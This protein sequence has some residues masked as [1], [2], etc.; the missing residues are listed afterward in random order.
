MQLIR[1]VRFEEKPGAFADRDDIEYILLEFKNLDFIYW[2]SHR[3]ES[4]FQIPKGYINLG[5][6]FRRYLFDIMNFKDDPPITVMVDKKWKETW[7]LEG[8]DEYDKDKGMMIWV[9]WKSKEED[10]EIGE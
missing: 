9:S 4:K 1:A 10:K 2:G 7:D 3:L 5:E 8:M 6:I